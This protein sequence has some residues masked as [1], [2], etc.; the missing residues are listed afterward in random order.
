MRDD[1]VDLQA[2][3][4]CREVGQPVV[5]PFG[6]AVLDGEVLPLHVAEVVKTLP[7][8]L[9]EVGVTSRGGAAQ[10]SEPVDLGLRLRI[11]GERRG[12]EAAGQRADK[13]AP[14]HYWI[15][16]SARASTD[17]GIVRPRAL[18][19]FRLMTSSNFVGCSRAGRR[20]WRP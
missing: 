4:F 8:G 7:E 1:E 10:E 9:H 11:G 5:L 20:A 6:P 19:V 13:R 14:V 12:E 15:T 3:Q 2:N 17:G 16:S 18:A